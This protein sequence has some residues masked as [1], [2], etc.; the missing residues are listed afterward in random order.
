MR[1]VLDNFPL[2]KVI[3]II[4]FLL[5]IFDIYICFYHLGK[6]PLDNWDEAWYGEVTKQM[7]KSHNFI[8]PM[9]NGMPFF[10]KPPLYMWLSAFFSIF[11]RLSEFSIRFTS[12]VS[13]ILI[14]TGVIYW[15]N[16]KFGIIPSIAAFATLALNN[17]FIW[18]VRSG[19]LDALTAFF[20]FISFFLILWKSKKRFVFL[21]LCFALLYL[22][23]GSFV[24][25]P[26][27]IFI[28]HELLFRR[29]ML[30]KDWLNYILLA[31]IAVVIPGIWLF[32]G[33][34]MAGQLFVNS[35]LF[36]SDQGEI[37]FN[38]HNFKWD[39]VLY[40]YYSLQRRY[41][42]ILILG[43]ILMLRKLK[44]PVCFLILI[45][46]ISLLIFLSFAEKSNNWY[47]V[48]I[49]PFF[50]MI[51]A[52]ALYEIIIFLRNNILVKS[53]ILI[54][55]LILSYKTYT[56][57]I[58]PIINTTSAAGEAAS[59]KYLDRHANPN[60]II[61]RLDDLYPSTIYYSNRIVYSS[62]PAYKTG[63]IQISSDDLKQKVR[64]KNQR[65]IVGSRSAVKDFVSQFPNFSY[66]LI[67]I[68]G[69]ETI[70]K[71]Y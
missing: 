6:A 40:T 66:K 9:W 57:N 51:I 48:P 68:N 47:L 63:G 41:F 35:Y 1:F 71:M 60:D 34:K 2:K 19:N 27:S 16:K 44:Q 28:I 17:L 36:N 53:L 38:L 50:S 70:A 59:G 54:V 62:L 8:I 61:V 12:A 69:Q 43:L 7:L 5:I 55:I 46:P 39:Y 58:L 37:G 45:F 31:F 29:K 14:L 13:G 22:T 25:F 56:I 33:Y 52:Y 15:V 24:F 64:S 18:R 11:L 30:L 32:I 65:W 21:G 20:V 26:M 49:T 3:N 23:K 67:Y 10:E 4:L 42:Y